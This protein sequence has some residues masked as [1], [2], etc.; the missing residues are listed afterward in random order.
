VSL[1]TLLDERFSEKLSGV[2]EVLGALKT[3]KSKE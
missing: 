1:L 3:D 2:K